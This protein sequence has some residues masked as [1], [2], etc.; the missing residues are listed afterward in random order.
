MWL[1]YLLLAERR[2]V[3]PIQKEDFPSREISIQI[4]P[5]K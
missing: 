3:F 5:I 2:L 4:G 1:S